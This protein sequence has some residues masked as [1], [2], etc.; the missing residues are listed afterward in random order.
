MRPKYLYNKVESNVQKSVPLLVSLPVFS[1]ICKEKEKPLIADCMNKY[2]LLPC[3][4]L[5]ACVS[6]GAQNYMFKRLELKD[7]LSNN[8]VNDIY[9]DSEGFMWFGTASGLN[10][11]DG[12][13][14]KVYLYEPAD[15]TSL[16]D[17]YIASIQE[18]RDGR[19]WIHTDRGYA[20]YDP[21]TDRFDRNVER[22]MWDRGINGAPSHVYIDSAKTYWIYFAWFK[23][24]YRYIPGQDKAVLLEDV[25]ETLQD[26]TLTSFSESDDGL[27]M[28]DDAGV[29][30]CLDKQSLKLTAT[31]KGFA[32]MMAERGNCAY[33]LYSDSYGRVWIY[34]MKGIACYDYWHRAW[35]RR[36]YCATPSDAIRAVMVDK[37]GR[38]WLGKDQDGV[39]I[40]GRDGKSVSVKNDPGNVRSL[41][42]NTV[43]AFY[44]DDA[45]T[46]WV[47]TYKKGVAMYNESIFKFD[48]WELGDIHCIEDGGEGITWLGTNGD[49]L[50][51]LDMATGRQTHFKHVPGDDHSLSGDVVTSLLRDSRGRLWV[52]TYI[53]GLNCFDGHRFTC[54]KHR[55]GDP[56]SLINDNVWALAED[57][58]GNIWIGTL[59]SGLQCLDPQTGNFTSYQADNSGL[60]S[61]WISSICLGRKGNLWIGTTGG[62]F[63]LD[64]K[65][66]K[67][68][69]FTGTRSGTSVFSNNV[70]IQLYEDSRGRLWVAT[71]AGLNVCDLNRDAVYE[72]PLDADASRQLVLGIVEDSQQGMWASVGGE[73]INIIPEENAETG[74]L[75]FRRYIYSD[76][77]G[78][79]SCDFNQR[80][81]ELLHT[82][83][84]VAGGLYGINAFRPGEIKYNEK[85]PRVMFT[86][87][88]LFNQDVQ[89]GVPIDGQVVLKEAMN[90]SREVVL[91]YEQNV[92]TV[93]LASDNY[94]LPE[95]TRF[96]YKLE[97]FNDEWL[98]DKENLHRVTYTNLAPGTYWLK[99]R[100]ANSDGFSGEEARLKIVILPPFWLTP[101]AYVLYIL[102]LIG[103]ILLAYDRVKRRERN[104]YRIR[105]IEEDARRNE[106][107]NQMK[108]RF[109]TN[110]SHELRTPL[111]LILS[112]LENLIKD[113]QDEQTGGKL[114]MIH[115]NALRLLN[116][117]NQL[118]DFRKNEMVGSHLSLSE[119]DMVSFVQ[120]ICNSFLMLSEKKGVHLTFHSDVDSLNM[121]FDADKIGKIVMNLLS[122]AF[123]FTPNG[124]LVTVSLQLP[125]NRPDVLEIKVADTGIGIK[126]EDKEHI[127]ER[128]YQVEHPGEQ[129]ASTGSGIGLSLVRDFV[130]LHGGTVQV[131]DNAGGGSVFV[132]AIPVKHI[133]M[134]SEPVAS[135][136]EQ[137]SSEKEKEEPATAVATNN[138]QTAKA[139]REKP[140]VLVVD[141][142]DDFVEFMKDTMNLYFSV[143]TAKNGKEALD[144]LPATHPDLILCDWMMP[145]MDGKE[146][147]KRVKSDKQTAGIPFIL[148]TAKQSVETKVE[149][150]SIG[151]DDY[152]TKPF[153]LEVLILRMRKLIELSRNA[154]QRGYIEPEP[155]EI[156]I[157]PLDEK[158]I[159]N[160]ISYVEKNISRSN[161]SVEE[162]S[163]ELGM[164]RAHMYKK[165]LQITGK[166]PIEFIRIIRLKRA[167]QLLRVSQQNVSEIAYQLGFNN[168]KY[169]SRYFKEEFGVLPSAY[170]EMEGKKTNNTLK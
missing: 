99:A 165:M 91:D 130:S 25:S 129:A 61:N 29:L 128:F 112:P 150:L 83:E 151:A 56:N 158:L 33:T 58:E 114:K 49:G 141:D 46:V 30:Y 133:A 131:F 40:I 43:T 124:G 166:T 52:G 72:V 119:G 92:F 144:M 162:L 147:C 105:Q 22:W 84:I 118:L 45:G 16:P 62:I 102:L 69:R 149:G 126:A 53:N 159:A 11:Y 107:L 75:S 103:V 139:K 24:L 68:S 132:V 34:G 115:R 170:Q 111:T 27:W 39:E 44:E 77:D 140:L 76:K 10:R 168:P 74:K 38:A 87:L 4:L 28:I 12:Y 32:E 135:G 145:V 95:K 19:L 47:G 17:N 134:P 117:V 65:T 97:G 26:V 88:R 96:Y 98:S 23:Q 94:I 36:S 6:L 167:A 7:G 50:V 142:N 60:A 122:N 55:S 153:N 104:K 110:V 5:L 116:L 85:L 48:L 113:V 42:N 123:K 127:F 125:D 66:R 137:S 161:L 20:L 2:F 86:G 89:V 109:F 71:R 108:F 21:A 1:F 67:I 9:K 146:L 138:R 155:E 81:L 121:A 82:G 8:Q 37:E 64:M 73:L 169:F 148:L 31:E 156:A 78:L 136:S 160:A 3:A 120:N 143:Q 79:Q 163:R 63:S 101:W 157:T 154:K 70:V 35:L 54:Y 57:A 18:D 41:P 106:E 80:S 164:S 15:T 14:M 13:N 100:A 59:G 152:V 93:F 51:R 90:R